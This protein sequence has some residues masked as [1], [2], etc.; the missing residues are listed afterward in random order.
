LSY[1][2]RILIVEDEK[3]VRMLLQRLLEEDGYYVKAV[4]TAQEGILELRQTEFEL[5]LLDLS[6]PDADGLDT[7]RRIRSSSPEMSILAMSGYMVGNMPQIARAA[8]A[9]ATLAKPMAAARLRS[10]VYELLDG[11]GGWRGMVACGD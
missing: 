9:D 2:P 1:A 10:A 7:M 5:L 3:P 6:L 11:T 4:E 8:G